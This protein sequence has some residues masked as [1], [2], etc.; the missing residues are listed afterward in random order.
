MGARIDTADGRPPVRIRGGARL[1]GLHYQMPVASAQVKSAVLLAGLHATGATT[2]LE[3]AV[4]RDHTER[5]LQAF[6]ALN[7]SVPANNHFFICV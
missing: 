4:T 7:I 1:A 2:V 6:G 3:P 5:M